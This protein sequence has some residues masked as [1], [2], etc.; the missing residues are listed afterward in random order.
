M[1]TG[2]AQQRRAETPGHEAEEQVFSK[3][4]GKGRH[5]QQKA[6]GKALAGPGRHVS[7]PPRAVSPCPSSAAAG[8][9]SRSPQC[10]PAQP[11]APPSQTQPWA[12]GPA[13]ASAR[14]HP[15]GGAW[16]LGAAPAAPPPCPAALGRPRGPQSLDPQP[17]QCPVPLPASISSPAVAPVG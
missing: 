15:H 4:E 9:V 1:V 16:V 11:W 8:P 14:P 13:W 2:G 6:V 3:R 5:P 7:P 12:G 17:L 10:C